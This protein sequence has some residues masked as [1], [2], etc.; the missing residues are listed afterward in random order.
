[1][2]FFD[3]Q[4]VSTIWNAYMRSQFLGNFAMSFWYL[5]FFLKNRYFSSKNWCF[6]KKASWKLSLR[7]KNTFGTNV[8]FF[9]HFWT[10]RKKSCGKTLPKFVKISLFCEIS[11]QVGNIEEIF[12]RVPWKKKGSFKA[13]YFYGIRLIDV[14]FLR[15]ILKI[16]TSLYDDR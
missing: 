12:Q 6:P 14:I 15:F 1:M 7:K 5:H 8:F 3:T 13:G 10:F 9:G 16:T 2:L 4:L 11:R